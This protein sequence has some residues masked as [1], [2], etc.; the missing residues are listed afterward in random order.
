MDQKTS[1]EYLAEIARLLQ[2]VSE[3]SRHLV[4]QADIQIYT[5]SLYNQLVA[6][7]YE[8]MEL[9]GQ[10]QEGQIV[11]SGWIA[12]RDDLIRRA[13]KLILDEPKEP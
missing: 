13:E 9:L 3:L 4:T 8:S 2:P 10:M 11:T 12:Q 1:K 6:L 5:E 7:M